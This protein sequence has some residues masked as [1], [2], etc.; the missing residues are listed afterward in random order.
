MK[1]IKAFFSLFVV[2][3]F[4]TNFADA[5]SAVYPVSRTE[6]PRSG[7]IWQVS[8]SAA[9]SY[10][11]S[12][13]DAIGFYNAIG[14][15]QGWGKNFFLD[16]YRW[17]TSCHEDPYKTKALG[18]VEH[19]WIDT[20]DIHYHIS[21]GVNQY[22]PHFQLNLTAVEFN[23]SNYL[24]PSEAIDRKAVISEAWGD[25]DLEW[26]AFR[27]CYLLDDVSWKYWAQSM[28]GLHMILGFR[29]PSSQA[30]K[31]GSTWAN[32]MKKQMYT[33]ASGV[34]VEKPGQ[35]V[36]SAFISA[37]NTT[38][39]WNAD[40]RI[41]A[42]TLSCLGDHLHGQG[43]TSPDP[44][45]DR[46]KWCF[47]YVMGGLSYC[48]VNDVNSMLEYEIIPVDVNEDYIRLIAEPFD[49][50]DE[51]IIAMPTE[52]SYVITA[53]NDPCDANSGK[54]I[55]EIYRTTGQYHFQNLAGLWTV[56]ACDPN[57]TVLSQAQAYTAAEN[58][59]NAYP[60]LRQAD[61]CDYNVCGDYLTKTDINDMNEPD[62]VFIQ[63][64]CVIYGRA[65]ET[66]GGKRVSV[67]GPGAKQKLYI[68]GNGEVIGAMGNW[69]KV[70]TAGTVSVMPKNSAWSLYQQYGEKVSVSPVYLSYDSVQTDINTATLAY[71]EASAIELQKRL[72]P[73]WIFNAE[74]FKDG[75][76]TGWADVFI[77]VNY[78]YF[79]PVASI[80]SP[81]QGSEVDFDTPVN[82][83]CALADANFGISPFKYEWFSDVDGLLSE[84][85]NFSTSSLTVSCDD[86]CETKPHFITLTITDSGGLE[87]TV[88]TSLT[89]NGSCSQCRHKADFNHDGIVDMKDFAELAAFWL[90]STYYESP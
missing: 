90:E 61:A 60:R 30:N 62:E 37:C 33:T 32:N 57:K 63:N 67:V 31:F 47:T 89:V 49:V 22:D 68:D 78:D 6:T 18:G 45:P 52:N 10:P 48:Q 86:K 8:A 77:P 72:I 70:Q 74:Y 39:P 88:S 34:Y 29:T 28:H 65:L 73:V 27:N 56:D 76:S 17:P 71:Y 5:G 20:S 53:L 36:A 59:L 81:S 75:N 58:F 79:R 54:R 3:L 25:G 14:G 7:C 24:V 15:F 55:L 83:E 80:T 41:V 16:Y 38:L 19:Q 64:R 1:L 42:E 23:D 50:N 11:P 13:P 40:A 69:R 9:T 46:Y 26:I 87:Y 84:Q 43:Y 4:L 85:Q 2:V 35:Q 44:V 82:F 66:Q 51:P 21:H 12:I